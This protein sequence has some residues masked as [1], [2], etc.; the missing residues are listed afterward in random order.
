MELVDERTIMYAKRN[1]IPHLKRMWKE[2]FGD[3]DAYI[4]FYFKYRFT[5]NNMLVYMIDNHPV[6]M[7]SMLTAQVLIDNI[8]QEIRYIYAVATLP[9]YQKQGYA[10][11]LI[12]AGKKKLQVPFVLEPAGEKLVAYYQNMGFKI[13]FFVEEV[14]RLVENMKMYEAKPLYHIGKITPLEYK[15][16]RD[17]FFW[18]EGYVCWDEEAIRYVLQENRFV[19]G[20][21]YK[22][23]IED[24][25]YML[26]GRIDA[27]TYEVIE[28]TLEGEL[29]EQIVEE[30]A[31]QNDCIQIVVRQQTRDKSLQMQ[32][33]EV[34]QK[35]NVTSRTRPLGMVLGDVPLEAGYLNLTLE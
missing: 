13:S 9:E 1:M 5:E 11:A 35:E 3:E 34:A 2:C 4:D 10:K 14:Y 24:K 20:N 33:L 29:L 15:R 25:E 6:S 16:L 30:L 12:L 8:L 23:T 32:E 18:Q 21:S 22:I 28:T 17:A 27:D 31:D 26:L 19:G 7:I